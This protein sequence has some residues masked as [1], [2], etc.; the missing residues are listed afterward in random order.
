MK[1][2]IMIMVMMGIILLSGCEG[3]VQGETFEGIVVTAESDAPT[4]IVE[5]CEGEDIRRSGTLISIGVPD[6]QNFQVGDKVRVT[7]E[8]PVMESHPL[9]INLLSIEKTGDG[10]K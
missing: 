4:I 8:G 9:Q 1:K 3:Q 5:P 7:H 2:V 10:T 6:E